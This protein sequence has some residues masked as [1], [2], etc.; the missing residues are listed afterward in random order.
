LDLNDGEY[1]VSLLNDCKYGCDSK[2]DRLRLTLLR[3][4]RWPDPEADRGIHEFTYAIYPHCGDWKSALTVRQGYELNHSLKAIV[5]EDI[6]GD[7]RGTLPERAQ[8]LD[9]QAEN[10]ILM[11]LKPSREGGLVMRCYECHGEEANLEL[12]GD[13]KMALVENL[14]LLERIQDSEKIDKNVAIAP[15]QIRTFKLR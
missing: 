6:G 12:A 1:G 13:L 10:L 2:R 11:A 3:S 7:S 8:F 4:S 15:W 14:D 9:L 5:G